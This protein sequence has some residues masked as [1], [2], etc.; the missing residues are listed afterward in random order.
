MS[1]MKEVTMEDMVIRVQLF[2]EGICRVELPR[3]PLHTKVYCNDECLFSF[4]PLMLPDEAACE[5]CQ[6]PSC[7]CAERSAGATG[8]CQ[9][10]IERYERLR[11]DVYDEQE[12]E[13]LLSAT[14]IQ[15]W[16]GLRS[17]TK[18]VATRELDVQ[19]LSSKQHMREHAVA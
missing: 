10:P 14:Y 9:F 15:D 6:E 16:G 4:V 7:H 17:E 3:T 5:A 12:T 13:L 2:D 18:Y 8:G 19:V 11:I 1:R